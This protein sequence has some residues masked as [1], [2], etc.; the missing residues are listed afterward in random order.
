[1]SSF[2][3]CLSIQ[4]TPLS[5]W[6]LLDVRPIKK[7]SSTAQCK[8]LGQKY[9]LDLSLEVCKGLPQTYMTYLHTILAMIMKYHA[10]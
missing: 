10:N 6:K 7:T 2:K 5:R 9:G 3:Q 1:M 8:T 4:P